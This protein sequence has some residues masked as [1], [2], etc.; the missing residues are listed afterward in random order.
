MA[1]HPDSPDRP[2]GPRNGV[3][4]YILELYALGELPASELAALDQRLAAD[5]NLRRRL[6]RLRA[7]NEEILARHPAGQFAAAV[8]QRLAAERAH[9]AR[10]R[11]LALPAGRPWLAFTPALAAAAVV[12][13]LLVRTGPPDSLPAGPSGTP[14]PEV[15]RIKGS[16]AHLCAYR[17]VGESVETLADRQLVEQGDVLQLSYVPM[18]RTHGAIVSID[19]R[20]MV[21]LHFPAALTQST[22]LRDAGE[23]MLAHAYELD[24]APDFERFFLVTADGPIDVSAL[25]AAARQLARSPDR[26]RTEFLALPDSLEQSAFMVCKKESRS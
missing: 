1:D 7:S 4:D 16:G 5:Q 26:A 11:K 14:A 10:G 17:R 22:R 6:D 18:G 24:D 9:P 19:G 21:T 3:P 8:E 2:S 23:S 13:L 15:T 25:L 12:I 20:G